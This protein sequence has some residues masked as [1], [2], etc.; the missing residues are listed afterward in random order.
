MQILRPYQAR[1][2]QAARAS[3]SA[4]IVAPPGAGKTTIAAEIIRCEP[5]RVLFLAHRRELISQAAARLAQFDV[6]V[7][8]IEPGAHYNAAFRV[9][10]ASVQ[11]L[12]RRASTVEA[13]ARDT[14]LVVIDEAHRALAASYKKITDAVPGAR[15]I[16]LTASPYRLDGRALGDLFGELIEAAQP[17][18]LV[19]AGYLIEP[20]VFGVPMQDRLRAVPVSGGDYQRAGLSAAM[21]GAKLTGDIVG[22]Y[23]RFARGQRAVCFATSV[24]HSTE[25]RDAMR[26]AGVRAEHVDAKTPGFERE[27][28][29]DALRAGR[30]DVVCNVEILTEGWDLPALG[31]VIL[32]RPTMSPGLFIQ[33]TGRVLRPKPGGGGGLIIDHAGCVQAHGWPTA[34]RAWSLTE[35]ER[36]TQNAEPLPGFSNCAECFAI[37][38]R[39]GKTACPE[40]GEEIPVN[41]RRRPS[42]ETRAELEELR[43]TERE[44]VRVRIRNTPG[45]AEGLYFR[46]YATGIARGYRDG[47]A[48]FRYK[49]RCGRWPSQELKAEARARSDDGLHGRAG[50]A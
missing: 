7:H 35:R 14:A 1:A 45:R 36:R 10:V 47:W 6:D 26:L 11:T 29:L 13:M 32:A 8:R 50:G 24:A 43:N 34:S 37:F 23:L 46:D 22:H 39:R 18:E 17:P 31:A 21:T 49:Q 42:C 25:I 12:A 40:C 20:R 2:V 28:I 33:M 44:Q 48:A 27:R 41:E 4:L 19:D 5:G 30:I 16:G 38:A 3:A 9:H 15:V